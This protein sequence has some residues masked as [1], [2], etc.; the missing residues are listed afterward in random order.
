MVGKT[1]RTTA[2][3]EAKKTIEEITWK[4][5]MEGNK[6]SERVEGTRWR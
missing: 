2:V 6:F 5:R 1:E 3:K 4:E